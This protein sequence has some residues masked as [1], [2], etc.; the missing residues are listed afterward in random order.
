VSVSSYALSRVLTLGPNFNRLWAASAFSNLGDGLLRVALPLFVVQLTDSPAAVAGLTVAA[1]AAWLLFGLP[2]G[3]LNDRLD[4]RRVMIWASLARS[5]ITIGL[6][7]AAVLDLVSLP[8]LYL[9]AFAVGVGEAFSD[10]AG[11]ALVSAVVQRSQ[12]QQANARR[13]GAALTANEFVGPSAGGALFALARWMPFT[14][15]A[16]AFTAAGM[17]ISLLRGDFRA[18]RPQSNDSLY[19]DVVSGIRYLLGES[20]V[21]VLAIWGFAGNLAGTVTFSVLVLYA[22]DP[23]PLG[24]TEA[25]YGLVLAG[26]GVGGLVG[27]LLVGWL[28]KVISERNIL[29]LMCVLM[30]A[31][32]AT[33]VLTTQI[34]LIVLALITGAAAAAIFSVTSMSLLQQLVPDELLSRVSAGYRIT[35]LAGIPV[36]AL[37][38]G[39]LGEITGD[40]RFGF[41]LAAFLFVA[42]T[43]LRMFLPATN[44]EHSRARIGS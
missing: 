30:A 31:E 38:A 14:I 26:L 23:G 16:A 18:T 9:F 41:A 29:A 32:S 20:T 36:G 2:A 37:I 3:A 34:P 10:T 15:A 27:T 21:R 44:F 7:L 13:Y 33:L 28:S 5:V 24:L 12:L 19:Q 4:R 6:V 25:R 39:S 43:G 8:V 1:N 35:F 42:L 40:L 22:V 17:A 11:P